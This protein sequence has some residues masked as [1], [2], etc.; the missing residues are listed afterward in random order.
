MTPNGLVTKGRVGFV[1]AACCIALLRPMPAG[2]QGGVNGSIVGYVFDQ[3]GNPIRGVKVVAR[4]GTQIGGGKVVYTNDEGY[5]RIVALLPGDFEVMATAPKLRSVVQKGIPVGINAPAEVS[6]VM[7]VE[8]SQVEDVKVVEKAPI[9]STTTANV[10]Y[11][12]DADF[13]ENLPLGNRGELSNTIAMNTPGGTGVGTVAG[14]SH[15][16]LQ[17]TVEGFQI[18]GQTAAMHSLAATEVHTAGYGAENAT[19]AGALINMVSKS[20]S[21][22]L[23]INVSGFFEDSALRLFADATDGSSRS[24]KYHLNPSFSG[25]IIKDRLWFFVSLE[26]FSNVSQAAEDPSGLKLLG[27]PVRPSSLEGRGSTKLTWQ[28]TPRNKLT[29]YSQFRY[30][31]ARNQNNGLQYEREAQRWNGNKAIFTGL[32]W[33][34]LL[35]DSLYLRSQVGYHHLYSFTAPQNCIADPDGCDHVRQVRGTFP[36]PVFFNTHDVHSVDQTRT[37]EVS[38]QLEWFAHS[39]TLGEHSI[40]A[41]VRNFFEDWGDAQSTP[42]DGYTQLTGATP[43]RQRIFYSNDPRVEEPRFGWALRNVNNMTH[44]ASLTDAMRITRY[45][46]FTPGL[47]YTTFQTGTIGSHSGLGGNA[48]TPHLS[49]AWDATHDGRTV[50]RASFNQYVEVPVVRRLQNQG[51]P[52]RVSQECRWNGTDAYNSQCTYSGGASGNTI[53]LP[54]SP[55]GFRADGS[56]CKEGLKIPRT[57]EYTAGAEREI[58]QGISLGADLIYKL[59][60]Y[61]YEV[62]ETNRL[63]APSGYMLDP[64]SNFKTGS[65]QTVSNLGTP[66]EVRR[67]YLAVTT[68]LRKREGAVK[69]QASYTWSRLEGNVGAS[70]SRDDTEFGSNPA[71]DSYY[72]YGFLAHDFRHN[73]RTL[74]TWQVTNWISFGT[75]FNYRSG[76]PYQRRFRNDV[77]GGFNDYRAQIGFNP[78]GNINDPGDD[79]ALRLPDIVDFGLHT[80]VNLKPLTGIAAEAYVDASNILALRTTTSVRTEDGPVWGTAENRLGPTR[81]RLGFRFRY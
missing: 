5:F 8:V 20:G 27:D 15:W 33:D 6:L 61:P 29:S 80:R 9:V 46:T 63:W 2:A 69:V 56:P 49:A 18:G 50:L 70:S 1:V 21:N 43:D 54:C 31:D 12:F 72:L 79:V 14:S 40:K 39:K 51:L 3:T 65:N 68:A 13:L 26:G 24:W 30:F 35:S 34:A 16:G 23:E 47:A 36:Q 41:K 58:V 10:K 60:T 67:R 55:T 38:N 59:Y 76:W 45:L 32:I 62:T 77:T 44:T 81:L 7:E 66:G 57:W 75:I 48:V 4:S 52:S 17:W 78:G 11:T 22:K 37:F 53:G 25:P 42:G 64:I 73:V 28:V 19:A 74:A 71:N